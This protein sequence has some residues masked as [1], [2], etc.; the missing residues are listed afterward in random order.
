MA[1]KSCSVQ[2]EKTT[3]IDLHPGPTTLLKLA[4][5]VQDALLDWASYW[6]P[7]SQIVA[8]RKRIDIRSTPTSYRVRTEKQCGSPVQGRGQVFRVRPVDRPARAGVLPTDEKD[9]CGWARDLGPFAILP[10]ITTARVCGGDQKR[11][12]SACGQSPDAGL[13]RRPHR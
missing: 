5:P 1:V 6:S 4:Q 8:L 13:W 11:Q 12:R 3:G 2:C 10:A 7:K 9:Q